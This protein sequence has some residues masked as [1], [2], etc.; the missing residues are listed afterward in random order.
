MST[1]VAHYHHERWDGSGYP[2]KLKENEIPLSAQ[3][4][5]VAGAY[6]S[7]TESRIYRDAY[8]IEAAL[9]ILELE[10]GRNFNP[11]IVDICKKIYRQFH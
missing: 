11:D 8:D 9:N 10:S 5:A 7:I 6:C 3:I 4:V 2:N 1:D